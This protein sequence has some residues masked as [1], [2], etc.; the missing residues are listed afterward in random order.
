MYSEIPVLYIVL[1]SFH[2]SGKARSLLLT[3]Y[4]VILSVSGEII[5]DLEETK[6]GYFEI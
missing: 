2:I 3:G 6:T 5:P 1:E 4:F